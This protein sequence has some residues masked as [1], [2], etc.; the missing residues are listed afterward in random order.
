MLK[1]IDPPKVEN[2]SVAVVKE[3]NEVNQTVWNVYLI[4]HNPV[5]IEGVLVTSKGYGEKDGRKLE[6][7]TLRHF[8]DEVEPESYKKIE[9]IMDDVFG[10][11]NEYWVSFYKEK[12]MFD[13]KFIFLAET[14]IKK[15]LITVPV[16]EKPGV[17]I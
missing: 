17:M 11:T 12:V 14:I 13:K 1:D 15:N 16:I 8:L 3:Q 10:L 6:T 9:P 7:T 2:V 4:N 5:T